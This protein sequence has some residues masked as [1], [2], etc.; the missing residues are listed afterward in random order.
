[1]NGRR[2]LPRVSAFLV[3]PIRSDLSS[4]RRAIP[5]P[6]SYFYRSNAIVAL[7]EI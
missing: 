2:Y 3:Q 6:P 5:R 7:A 1:M 4:W